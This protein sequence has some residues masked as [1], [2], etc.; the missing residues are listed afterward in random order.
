MELRLGIEDLAFA[1]SAVDES[2]AAHDLMLAQLGSMSSS[3]AR[4][5]LMAAGHSLMARELLTMDDGSKVQL[6]QPLAEVARV[7]T[8]ADFMIR[9]S[10]AYRDA[11]FVFSFYFTGGAILAHTIEKGVVH[12]IYTVDD[13]QNIV[14]EAFEF[15]ELDDTASFPSPEIE[16]PYEVFRYIKGSEV[17]SHILEE[18][19][20]AD[21]PQETRELLAEDLLVTRFRGSILRV[22]G[23]R[24]DD[25][26]SDEG[27][28]V[29][30]G[31]ERLWLFPTHQKAGEVFVTL[32]SGSQQNFREEIERLVRS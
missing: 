23:L 1:L 6:Q 9:Y 32:K 29:L 27:I 3:E 15:F 2:K 28:L 8:H 10:R 24:R 26:A 31:A 22:E 7:L 19:A 25:P 17:P 13:F 30:R 20:A 14:R 11:E 4:A 5:R 18:L 21:V 16:V 12:H